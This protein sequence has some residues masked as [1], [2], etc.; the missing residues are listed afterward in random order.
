MLGTQAFGHKDAV[1]RPGVDSEKAA[2]GKLIHISSSLSVEPG[3]NMV[4]HRGEHG[5]EFFESIN[6]NPM[7]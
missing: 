1:V 2:Q 5:I 6:R 7:E 4:P 3:T